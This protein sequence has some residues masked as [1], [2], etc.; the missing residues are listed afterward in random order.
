M[1]RLQ[2]QEREPVTFHRLAD[3]Y[4]TFTN[5]SRHPVIID[6]LVWPTCEHYYQAAKVPDTELAD[7]IRE[8]P[9]PSRARDLG[10]STEV[11]VRPDWHDVSIGVMTTAMRA[12]FVQHPRLAHQLLLTGQ[13]PLIETTR[14]DYFW[15]TG[16]DGSGRNTTG[17]IL[18]EIRTELST[19]DPP[20]QPAFAQG[21]RWVSFGTEA[22]VLPTPERP[23]DNDFPTHALRLLQSAIIPAERSL[24]FAGDHFVSVTVGGAGEIVL[25]TP[26]WTA[27][28]IDDQ[29][30][31]EQAL[32]RAAAQPI[33]W[34]HDPRWPRSS[35]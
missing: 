18:T 7:R 17:Q 32:T 22:I 26:A 9:T 20:R 25:R 28:G 31:L 14:N 13:R 21:S 35:S 3:E 19:T 34:V 30:D 27:E 23:N 1:N 8:A 11:R 29:T 24:I 2:H 15:G 4:G 10:R 5:Y 12:K 33:T 16:A 6:G